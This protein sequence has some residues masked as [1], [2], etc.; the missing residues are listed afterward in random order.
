MKLW[1]NGSCCRGRGRV[2]G[3]AVAS[4]SL[5]V[6]TSRAVL[7]RFDFSVGMTPGRTLDCCGFSLL[8]A[9]WEGGD[10]KLCTMPDSSLRVVQCRRWNCHERP[11]PLLQLSELT[12]VART[13]LC[14]SNQATRWGPQLSTCTST[15]SGR[16]PSLYPSSRASTSQ[17]QH[18]MQSW[19]Q[20]APVGGPP[21]QPSSIAMPFS[22]GYTCLGSMPELG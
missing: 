10:A 20:R 15:A 9:L 19:R 2:T 14:P 3:A 12:T 7:L 1:L 6:V 13:L 17:L 4:E 21:V 5:L 22:Y 18:G 16:K 8:T 11:M